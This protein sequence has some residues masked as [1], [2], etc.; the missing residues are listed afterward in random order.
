MENS[1]PIVVFDLNQPGNIRRVIQ[2]EPVGT[3]V[4]GVGP[5]ASKEH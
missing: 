1:I 5:S 3:V 4:G 2:G